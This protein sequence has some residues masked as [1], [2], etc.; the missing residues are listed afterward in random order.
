MHLWIS[1]SFTPCHFENLGFGL[2]PV[3]QIG[4]KEFAFCDHQCPSVIVDLAQYKKDTT[5]PAFYKSKHLEIR[6]RYEDHEAFFTDGSN[7]EEWVGAAVYSNAEAYFWQLTDGASLFSAELKALL[8]ALE[9]DSTSQNDKFIISDS[10][11][12]AAYPA[13]L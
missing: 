9:C 1:R 8:L 2:F 3:S 11:V 12:S 5:L 10:Y 4:L 6:S 7:D 13:G